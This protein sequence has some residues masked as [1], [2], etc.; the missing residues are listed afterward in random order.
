M[1]EN[2]K[3]NNEINYIY[4]NEE[5]KQ[6]DNQNENRD[7]KENE[8]VPIK[9]NPFENININQRCNRC[10]GDVMLGITYLGRIILTLY[11]FHGLFFVYNCIFQYII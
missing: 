5:E 2:E 9:S 7:E 1:K 8:L 6:K 4:D 10:T 3:E 11:T